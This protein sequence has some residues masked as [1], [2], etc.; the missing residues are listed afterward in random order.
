MIQI[1]NIIGMEVSGQNVLTFDEEQ[2]LKCLLDAFGPAFSLEDIAS[3][4]CKASRNADLAAEILN[5]MQGSSST[6]GTQSSKSDSRAE[7]T[8]VS[9]DGY[10]SENPCQERKN[11]R[12]KARP[13][14]LGSVSGVIGKDYVRPM[15]SA[16]G[17]YGVTKPIKLDA[18]EFPMT[19][20]WREKSK[21]NTFKRDQLHKDMEDFLFKMLGEGFQLDRNMIREVLGT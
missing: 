17:S 4:Y 9:S 19:G 16:N 7:E 12:H 8:S 11:V 2:A 10:F 13:V 20:I 5:E 18:K 21:P 1:S 15:P 3:A 14:S 6:S